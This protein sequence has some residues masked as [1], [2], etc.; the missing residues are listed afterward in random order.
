MDIE[1]VNTEEIEV[2]DEAVED[3]EKTVEIVLAIWI[4]IIDVT[5]MKEDHNISETSLIEIA[6]AASHITGIEDHLH[7]TVEATRHLMALEIIEMLLQTLRSIVLVEIRATDLFRAVHLRQMVSPSRV[8]SAGHLEVE[9]DAEEVDITTIT[10]VADRQ[11]HLGA[12]ELSLQRLH[13]PKCQRL[14]PIWRFLAQ[15]L[16]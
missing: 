5:G 12:A 2:E 9:E 6:G 1:V 16:G 11:S 7:L 8:A 4:E 15:F 10:D 13:L 14:V 3:G